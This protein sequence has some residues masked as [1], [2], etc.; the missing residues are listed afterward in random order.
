MLI[1]ST[2]SVYGANEKMPYSEFDK[3]IIKCHFTLRRK[4]QLKICVI[5]IHIYI[6]FQL[7]CSDSLLFMDHGVVQHGFI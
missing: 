1:A 3:Q 2:S 7:Q 4:N 5:V 6:T